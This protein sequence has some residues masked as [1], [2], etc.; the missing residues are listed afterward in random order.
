M[1]VAVMQG[2]E[3]NREGI[4]HFAGQGGRLGELEVVGFSG[5]PAADKA[6]MR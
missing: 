1:Q 6:G 4:R 2:A 3:G 5:L